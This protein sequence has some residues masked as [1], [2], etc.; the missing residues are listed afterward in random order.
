MT[1]LGRIGFRAGLAAFAATVSYDVVQI[2]QLVGAIRFPAD[3]ILIFGASLCIVVPFVLEML[4]LHYTSAADVRFWTHAGLLFT[5]TYAA[6]ASANYVI[7]LSTVIPAKLR[8]DAASVAVLDQ[9]PHSLMW[10]FDALA[11]L[12][13]G[14]ATASV[15]PALRQTTRERRVRLAVM[16]HLVATVLSGI[17]Y[18]APRYSDRLLLLGFPWAITAPAFMLLLAVALRDRTAERT[19]DIAAG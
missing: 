12:S 8:G 5:T 3:E 4:A 9:T 2:L 11:Y 10:D 17:V 14:L 18:F 1:S 16:A 19:T 6:F 15:L 7:Q 13:M